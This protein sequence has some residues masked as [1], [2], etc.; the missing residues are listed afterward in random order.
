MRHRRPGDHLPVPAALVGFASVS[1]Q[2]GTGQADGFGL[3]N[4]AVC[5]IS[6]TACGPTCA[7]ASSSRPDGGHRLAVSLPGGYAF[8][9]FSFPFKNALFLVTLAIL[10]VPYASLLIPLYVLLKGLGL[11]D[12]L[13][14]L[15]LVMAMFQLPFAT[16]MM[17]ISFEAVPRE[18]EEAALV[19]G[20]G[21][22]GVLRRIMLPAVRPGV[23]TVACSP[24]WPPGT[25]SSRR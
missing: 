4:Y 1:P 12:S 14:G 25:T 22:F 20:A 17:R 2:A 16:F 8:A 15:S 23:V 13:V 11:Q 7:T 5:S 10:M 18:L 24:S 19:D 9:R 3:G 21:S 6:P